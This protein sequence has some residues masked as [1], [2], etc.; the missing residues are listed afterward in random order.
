MGENFPKRQSN[1][2]GENST[3]VLHM[4]VGTRFVALF[5]RKIAG[6]KETKTNKSISICLPRG[7]EELLIQLLLA[8]EL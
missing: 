6:E 2:V 5:V 3:C 4:P 8:H 7:E 1:L